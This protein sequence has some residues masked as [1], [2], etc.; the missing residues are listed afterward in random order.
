M[1]EAF[2]ISLE[3]HCD[4]EK[5]LALKDRGVEVVVCTDP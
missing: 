5:N 4:F 2:K 3:F 1:L